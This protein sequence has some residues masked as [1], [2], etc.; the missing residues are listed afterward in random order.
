MLSPCTASFSE[1]YLETIKKVAQL[2]PGSTTICVASFDRTAHSLKVSNYGDSGLRRY[3][4]NTAKKC[5]AI[6]FLIST[7]NA[8]YIEQIS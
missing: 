6:S 1:G 4:L 3:T 5:K 2:G 8:S 7:N